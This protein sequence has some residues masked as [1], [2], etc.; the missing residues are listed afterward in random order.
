M[1]K[2]DIF[3]KLK[4]ELKS[5]KIIILVG[6][7]QSGKTTLLKLLIKYLQKRAKKYVYLN[8]DVESDFEKVQSQKNFLHFLKLELGTTNKA[9]VFIDEIQ[10]KEN[11]GLFL[12]GLYDLELP[13]KFIVSGSGSVELKEKVSE[14]LAG[15]K[16]V[17]YLNTVTFKEFVNY[18]TDYRYDKNLLEYCESDF[19]DNNLFEE[20]LQFGGYPEVITSETAEQKREVIRSIYESFI[21]K[22]IKEL[23]K[24]KESFLVKDLLT[25]LSTQIGHL[26]PVSNITNTI[27]ISFSTARRYLYYLEKV[28]IIRKIR[29]FYKNPRVE[30]TKAPVYYFTDLGMRNFVFNELTHFDLIVS[31]AMLFQNFVYLLLQQQN[32]VSEIKYWRT[33]GKAEVD[34]VINIGDKVL[35]IEV[36]FKNLK[37][38]PFSKSMI[39]FINKYNPTNFIVVNKSYSAIREYKNTKVRFVTYKKLVDPNFVKGYL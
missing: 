15:R 27:N 12:K 25:F 33:K 38:A 35:P 18:K 21:D 2:R 39:S 36:K 7:R 28:F 13:Y 32:S 4:K 3:A 20:Y 11:A 5:D 22:D 34:F 26:L 24:V 23:L 19:F 17:F 16:R 14:S 10:R 30:L 31:G 29:A 1:I 8:L 6:P 9:Y 37:G